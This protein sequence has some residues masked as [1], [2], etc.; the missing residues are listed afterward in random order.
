MRGLRYCRAFSIA[1]VFALAAPEARRAAAAE[2]PVAVD[3]AIG[4]AADVSRSI[5][6]IDYAMLDGES[7]TLRGMLDAN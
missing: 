5:D 3:A 4:L 2:A 7:H 1:A 6:D